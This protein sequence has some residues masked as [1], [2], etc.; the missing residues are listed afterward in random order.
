MREDSLGTLQI[1]QWKLSRSKQDLLLGFDPAFTEA[2]VVFTVKIRESSGGL[3]RPTLGSTIVFRALGGQRALVVVGNPAFGQAVI[4]IADD[5]GFHDLSIAIDFVPA[6]LK[7][8]TG[9]ALGVIAQ[10][11]GSTDNPP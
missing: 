7:A 3:R 10:S 5:I 2:R 9:F 1:L 11:L 8:A 4:T 6:F